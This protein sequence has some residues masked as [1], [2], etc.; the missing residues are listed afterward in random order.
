MI[1]T[2]NNPDF[3]N[4]FLQYIATILNKSENT[5]KEYNYDLNH[6]LKFIMY[7]F[8]L[9]NEEN[10]KDI[11]IKNM[12]IDTIKK[13]QLDDIHAFLFYL[14]NTYHSKSATRARKNSS[15]KNQTTH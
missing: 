11:N 9:S 7:H 1:D 15:I 12:S 14:T 2:A 4:A 13:I 6:F 10:I 3:L 5:V 8:H